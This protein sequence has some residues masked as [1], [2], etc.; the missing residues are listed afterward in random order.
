MT[1]YRI[2]TSDDDLLAQCE[3]DIFG[4]GGPGGQNVNRRSTAVRLR[5][6]PTGIVVV[7]RQERSQHQNRRIALVILRRKIKAHLYVPS[8]RIAT[9][10]PRSAR[11][12]ILKQ[13]KHR[14][15]RKRLRNAPGF[16]D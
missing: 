5:H 6:H 9:A 1:Q 14:S 11:N 10:M 2:P 16:D 3:I 15:E 4:A 12:R 7:C 8:R 13:K